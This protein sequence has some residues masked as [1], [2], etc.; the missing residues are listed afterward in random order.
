MSDVLNSISIPVLVICILGLV[1]LIVIFIY[2]SLVKAKTRVDETWRQIDVRLQNRYDLLPDLIQAVEKAISTDKEIQ[3]KIAE[4]RS[5]ADVARTT[6]SDAS[7]ANQKALAEHTLTSAIQALRVTLEA[8]PELKSQEAIKNF[9]DQ[10]AVIEE[11]I[12][13]ARQIYNT[14]A[15]EYNEKIS[16]IPNNILASLMGYKPVS[17]FEASENAKYD[18]EPRWGGQYEI[19]KE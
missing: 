3:T 13:A 17:Y 2:N 12:A 14:T 11:K 16:I 10:D 1:I 9:M 7:H 15:R 5:A 18:I 8:Y 19:R 6:Q 4:L